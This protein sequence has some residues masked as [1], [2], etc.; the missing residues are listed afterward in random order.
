MKGASSLLPNRETEASYNIFFSLE[1]QAEGFIACQTKQSFQCC[2]HAVGAGSSTVPDW[3]SVV[4]AGSCSLAGLL[5]LALAS[6]AGVPCLL[7][8]AAPAATTSLAGAG[9]G[10]GFMCGGGLCF[11]FTIIWR[12]LERSVGLP[13]FGPCTTM[14]DGFFSCSFF[15]LF[16]SMLGNSCGI[17]S[18]IAFQ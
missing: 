12:I 14:M 3:P 4:A 10:E 1:T 9:A 2:I 15:P 5:P 8:V 18:E 11:S 16:F 17:S 13:G 6:L 7:P